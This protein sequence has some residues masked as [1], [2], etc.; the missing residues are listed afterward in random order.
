M[1]VLRF[2]LRD[3]ASVFALDEQRALEQ[4]ARQFL[5][6]LDSDSQEGMW[7]EAF[8]ERF[9]SRFAAALMYVRDVKRSSGAV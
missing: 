8:A 9:E 5:K 4:E 3:V 7:F 1:D 2:I 6:D